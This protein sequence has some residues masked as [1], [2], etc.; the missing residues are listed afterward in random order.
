M[1][2]YVRTL[3]CIYI[4]IL[5]VYVYVYKIIS[6]TKQVYKVDNISKLLPK[7]RTTFVAEVIELL[8]E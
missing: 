3:E 4:C 1:H 2:M 6:Q 8:Y 5:T 7:T